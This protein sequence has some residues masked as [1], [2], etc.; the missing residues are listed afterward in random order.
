M[1]SIVQLGYSFLDRRNVQGDLSYLGYA[2][3]EMLETGDTE[4][5]VGGPLSSAYIHRTGRIANLAGLSGYEFEADVF[6]LTG[7]GKATLIAHPSRGS[8]LFGL[9]LP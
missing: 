4:R 1:P 7:V 2:I 5:I 6:S 9:A 8:R 3:R